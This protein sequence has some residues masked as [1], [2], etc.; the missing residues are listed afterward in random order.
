M[1]LWSVS[2]TVLP[3]SIAASGV[4]QA[5]SLGNFIPHI[6]FNNRASAF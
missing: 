4:N 5:V 6:V 2:Q 3:A 1:G